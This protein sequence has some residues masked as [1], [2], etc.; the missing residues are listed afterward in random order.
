MQKIVNIIS[1]FIKIKNFEAIIVL[2]VLLSNI[3]LISIVNIF[4]NNFEAINVK[5]EKKEVIRN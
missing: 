3:F 2:I 4:Y 1:F 5:K